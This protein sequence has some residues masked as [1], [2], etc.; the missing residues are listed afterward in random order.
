MGFFLSEHVLTVEEVG[1]VQ[2]S[3]RLSCL[4]RADGRTA[5]KHLSHLVRGARV[6]FGKRRPSSKSKAGRGLEKYLLQFPNSQSE[7]F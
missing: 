5:K 3:N 1:L 7:L 4:R 6:I 2:A